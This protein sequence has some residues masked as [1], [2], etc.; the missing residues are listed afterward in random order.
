MYSALRSRSGAVGHTTRKI[1][2]TYIILYISTFSHYEYTHVQVCVYT[3]QQLVSGH[4]VV[5][6]GSFLEHDSG[7][8]ALLH[9]ATS[10]RRGRQRSL[11]SHVILVLL[12]LLRAPL[13]GLLQTRRVTK[14]VKFWQLGDQ[15]VVGCHCA[16]VLPLTGRGANFTVNYLGLHKPQTVINCGSWKE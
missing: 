7:G 1:S 3:F 13:F 12:Q 6:N 16:A 15:L 5:E 9:H 2:Y 8:G 4:H 10:K 11:L 14:F